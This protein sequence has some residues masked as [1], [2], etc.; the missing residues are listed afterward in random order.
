MSNVIL[1]Q[2]LEV[3]EILGI[4]IDI[5]VENQ[6]RKLKIDV[7]NLFEETPSL[8]NVDQNMSEREQEGKIVADGTKPSVEVGGKD[9]T[10]KCNLCTSTFSS[11]ANLRRHIG[12][13][14]SANVSLFR[15]ASPGCSFSTKQKARLKGHKATKH[16]GVRFNCAD[17]Q[18]QTAWREA[19]GKHIEAKHNKV[20]FPWPCDLCT[21]KGLDEAELKSHT[22]IKH[23]LH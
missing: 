13:N 12:M 16:N 4:D 18:F 21:F 6:S 15:C 2:V 23:S 19:L 22:K 5:H 17:C 20:G 10:I 8:E 3:A 1:F 9:G 14:H 7:A 11:T